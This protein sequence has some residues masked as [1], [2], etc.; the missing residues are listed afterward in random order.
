MDEIA[1]PKRGNKVHKKK[2]KIVIV[3]LTYN[4]AQL[5]LSCLFSLSR[6]KK[7]NY[8]VSTVV[9]DNGSSDKTSAIIS[10]KYPR[11][12]IIRN[13]KNYGFS[14]GINSGLKYAFKKGYDWIIMLNDDTKV[15]QNFLT[16]LLPIALKNSFAICG[17]KIKTIDNKIWSLGGKIDKLRFSGGLIAYGKKD[18]KKLSNRKVDYISGTAM[19]VKREV[20]EK[21]GFLDEDY[22]LY[23]DDAD[24]CFRASK[25]GFNS[26]LIPEVEIKHLETVTI[27]KNSPSHYYH[28]AK[29]HLIF[30]LKRAPLKI[31]IRELLRLFK[32]IFELVSK[33]PVKRKYE[34]LAIKDFCLGRINI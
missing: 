18:N 31:K 30:V 4:H 28:A 21:I 14:K 25:A 32:T 20:F 17:P 23:Y 10:Q 24:F 13:K 34:L 8:S 2:L 11:I 22:F 6:I 9:V 3:V 33:D 7:S 19:L 26:Y 15:P 5:A 12:K 1:V 29:S 27:K 16:G